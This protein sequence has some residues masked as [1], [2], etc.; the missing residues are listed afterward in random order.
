MTENICSEDGQLPTDP[1]GGTGE[2][3]LA[4]V[5][6]LAH[7]YGRDDGHVI[8][9]WLVPG[10]QVGLLATKSLGCMQLSSAELGDTGESRCHVLQR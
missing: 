2:K 8:S 6:A 5:L 1:R 10:L 9:I 7:I 3:L 4:A